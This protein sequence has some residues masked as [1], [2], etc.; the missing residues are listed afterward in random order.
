MIDG[1][2]IF[3]PESQRSVENVEEVQLKAVS[4]LLLQR[5]RFYPWSAANRTIART[6]R[7]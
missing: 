7:E 1:I 4:D 5:G 3:D 2:R 6:E